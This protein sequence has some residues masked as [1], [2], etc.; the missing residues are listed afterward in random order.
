[1]E[2]KLLLL[3]LVGLA[4]VVTLARLVFP[5]ERP[6]PRSKYRGYLGRE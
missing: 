4:V 1:V 6:Q 5:I 3:A 2:V